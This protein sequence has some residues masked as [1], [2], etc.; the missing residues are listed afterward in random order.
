MR[1]SISGSAGTG[2]TTLIEAF[3]KRWPMYKFPTKTYRDVIT[4]KNLEHSS[5]TTGET[6]LT[7]LDWMMQVQKNYPKDSNVI[8]DRCPID[9]LVY[10]LQGNASGGISD[11]VAGATISLVRE[12]MKDIDII[13]WLKKHPDIKIVEDGLR[14]TDEDYIQ[15]TEKIFEDLYSQYSDDLESD[16]FFPKEDCP[17]FVCIDEAFPS[18]DDRLAFIGEFIDYKGDLIETGESVL[19]PE[20]EELL[21]SLI[22]EQIDA[23]EGDDR[24]KKLIKEFKK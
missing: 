19:N 23:Q 1:I 20:N 5:K 2:K 17:A 24:I 18:V 12:S 11:E 21:K 13:F 3:K 7:I 22:G 4:E 15:K 8:Y 10:T 9:N 16:V 6:Q 14:D